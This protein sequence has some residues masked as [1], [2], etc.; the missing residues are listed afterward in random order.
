MDKNKT[1]LI[2]IL[3]ILVIGVLF[4]YNYYDKFKDNS[5]SVNKSF[6]SKQFSG[7]VIQVNDGIVT[8]SQNAGSGSQEQII[9]FT[10]TPETKFNKTLFIITVEQIKSG[11]SYQ[12]EQKKSEGSIADL[13]PGVGI[14]KLSSKEDISAT[15][16]KATAIE[17][18]YNIYDFPKSIPK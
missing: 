5:P 13:I 2:L 10:T 6:V 11:K 8:V 17:I 3:I 16:S 14:E 15:T 9:E 1:Y 12:P 18:N 4:A 7:K